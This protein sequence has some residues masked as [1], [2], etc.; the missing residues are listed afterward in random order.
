MNHLY[1]AQL[2]VDEGL[3]H[4]AE[5]LLDLILRGPCDKYLEPECVLWKA[6]ARRLME[7]IHGP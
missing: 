2:F 5:Y 6:S 3:K 1:L 7:D 4:D